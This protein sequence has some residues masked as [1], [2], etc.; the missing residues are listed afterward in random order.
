M[1]ARALLAALVSSLAAAP[2]LGAQ[3][4]A[5]PPWPDWP[6]FV[7]RVEKPGEPLAEALVA[8]FGGVNVEGTTEDDWARERGLDF[9]VGHGPGRD[10]LHIDADRPWYAELWQRYWE[11]R[12]PA[13]LLRRPCLSEGA[14]LE[15]LRRHL[16]ASLA[17]RDGDRGLG[18]S[19]GDEVGLTPWGA[20]LDLCESEACREAYGDFLSRSER[21]AFLRP[22]ADEALDYPDT[23]VTRLAWLEG[24][25]RHV[26]AWLA[27]REF[28]RAQVEGVL[29][30]LAAQLRSVAPGTRVGLFGQSGRTPFGDVGVEAVLEF[31]DFLEV[32]RVL[33][34]RELLYTL[35]TPEQLSLLTLQ[36]DEQ[37]PWAATW[38]AWEHWLRGGDG[39][40]IWADRVLDEH[41]EYRASLA[42]AVAHIRELRRELPGWRPAPEGVAVIHDPDSLALGWLRDALNDGPTWMRRYASYQNEHGTRELALRALLRLL[43]DAG[44]LPGALPLER[45]GAMTVERFPV[46][47]ANHLL[48][49]GPEGRAGLRAYLEAGGRLVVVGGFDRFDRR[50]RRREPGGLASLG[51]A[52]SGA[53]SFEVDGARYLA[54]RWAGGAPGSYARRKREELAELCAPA[55]RG[56]SWSVELTGNSPPWLRA[57]RPAPED[58]A[59]LCAALPNAYARG[60]RAELRVLEARLALPEGWDVEW[61]HPPGA[62]EGPVAELPPGEALVFRLLEP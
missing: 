46:L 55:R 47:V 56:P 12:E 4:A 26:G 6:A 11:E 45:V 44:F 18:V 41:E 60:E 40:V 48:L 57:A 3:A 33:D 15:E 52:A 7:W 62:G 34:A 23:D 54:E 61:I 14:T 42:G 5:P 50:G 49:P 25:A 53:R 13:Q 59:W 51:E 10:A 32:Y 16:A 8:P 22:G 2:V 1:S 39:V 38:L 19:L 43:E 31:L 28:H 29:A 21:W 35:R 17:A 24:D 20:P 27:R 9:F 36:R 37:A 30:Q 58:G